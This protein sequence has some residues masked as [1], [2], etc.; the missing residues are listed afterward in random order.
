MIRS[1]SLWQ[2]SIATVLLALCG[3]SGGN[4]APAL[5]QGPGPPAQ[6]PGPPAGTTTINAAG[7]TVAS[8]DKKISVSIAAG[9]LKG[10][11]Y[12]KIVAKDALTGLPSGYLLVTGTAFGSLCCRGS[13]FS[14]AGCS[15]TS[16]ILFS[17]PISSN[18]DM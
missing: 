10:D 16:R 5:A 13:G 2:L 3:C 9:A 12:F 7:G 8:S 17:S 4:S 1:Q 11:T 18:R 15:G 14:S 6:S